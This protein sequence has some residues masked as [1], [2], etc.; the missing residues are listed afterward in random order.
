M[1]IEMEAPVDD[2]EA[3]VEVEDDDALGDAAPTP[4]CTQVDTVCS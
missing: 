1:D 4:A 2:L 3:L